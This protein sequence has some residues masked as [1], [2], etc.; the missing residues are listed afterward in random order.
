[1]VNKGYRRKGVGCR[2]HQKGSLFF[3]YL[4]GSK[5]LTMALNEQMNDRIREALVDVP[6]VTEKRMF[7]GIAFMVNGKL[8]LSAGNDE[9]MCR[10]D[11][12]LHEEAVQKNDGYEGQGA[13]RVHLCSRR[14]D[15]KQKRL[16][17]LDQYGVGLQYAGQSVDQKEEKDGGEEICREAEEEIVGM[18]Y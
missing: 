14:R 11:P 9:M 1:M 13:Q 8:C 16:R 5:L 7:R 6:R 3:C 2:L 10:I 4:V 15:E 12:L 17:P 18:L